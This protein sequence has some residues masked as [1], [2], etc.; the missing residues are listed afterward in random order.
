MANMAYALRYEQTLAFWAANARAD[1][2]GYL[3]DP[4]D[5]MDD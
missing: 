3:A 5:V 1:D 4:L 2:D